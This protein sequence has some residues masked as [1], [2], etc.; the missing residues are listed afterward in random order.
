MIKLFFSA[1]GRIGPQEFI[2]GAVILL[3]LNFV[4]WL[5]WFVSGTAGFV[6]SLIALITIFCWGC[7]FTK[8]FHDAGLNGWMFLPT[9]LL[10][11]LL[12]YLIVPIFLNPILPAN[13]EMFEVL[14]KV[15]IVQ[16]E[17]QINPPTTLRGIFSPIL[18]LFKEFYELAALQSAIIYFVSGV[19]TAF[20]INK[21]LKTDPNPNQWG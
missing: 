12:A 13:E 15:E 18:G 8:R 2:K 17:M 5:A 14:D 9:F 10:F 7:L 19:I 11:L 20:G 1:D 4:L 16:E 6:A 21:L 3:A